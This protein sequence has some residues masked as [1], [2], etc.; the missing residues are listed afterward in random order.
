MLLIVLCAPASWYHHVRVARCHGCG[1]CCML[2]SVP[3]A[4]CTYVW[5]CL[6]QAAVACARAHVWCVCMYVCAQMITV[7]RVVRAMMRVSMM[8]VRMAMMNRQ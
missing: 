1:F 5:C 8:R 3:V 6:Q 4:C 2:P 7:M